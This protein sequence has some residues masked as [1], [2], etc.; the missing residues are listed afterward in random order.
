MKNLKHILFGTLAVLAVLILTGCWE[1]DHP[2]RTSLNVDTSTLTLTVGE[3]ATRT[4][5][6][7]AQWDYQITYTS[8]NPAVATVDQTGQ[9]TAVS[10]GEAVITVSMA[11]TIKKLV[12]RRNALLQC[13][14]EKD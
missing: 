12:C 11:E 6:T 10:E 13:C 4:A 2:V 9:V 8:S 1:K 5:T 7:K 3:S 14:C